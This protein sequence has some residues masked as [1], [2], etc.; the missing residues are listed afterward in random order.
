MAN[1]SV[2]RFQYEGWDVKV[3]LDRSTLDGVISGHADLTWKKDDRACRIAL[4][5]KHKDGASAIS[6]LSTKARAYIDEWHSKTCIGESTFVDL[7]GPGRVSQKA[8]LHDT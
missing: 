1:T 7:A 6:S 2:H 5:G 4:A 3:E 8:D